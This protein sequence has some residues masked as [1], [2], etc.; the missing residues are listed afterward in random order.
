MTSKVSG[1][2]G[3]RVEDLVADPVGDACLGLRYLDLL[4]RNPGRE[5][6]ALDIT[7]L[8]SAAPASTTPG[9]ALP[10]PAQHPV[11]GTAADDI[12]DARALA[13]YRRRLAQNPSGPG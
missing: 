2:P 5:L 13:E 4:I 10:G 3:R 7:Q 9:A 8:A 12:L 11:T 1:G 6:A